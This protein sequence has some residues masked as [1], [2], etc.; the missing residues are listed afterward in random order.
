[1]CMYLLSFLIVF[2]LAH[3]CIVFLGSVLS[4]FS[5]LRTGILGLGPK[6][7]F[8]FLLILV[9]DNDN[10]NDND[11]VLTMTMT[12]FILKITDPSRGIVEIF[13]N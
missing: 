8:S 9:H 11:K 12:K 7:T 2:E 13:L 1:M 6:S 5:R 4:Q 10:D 3:Y